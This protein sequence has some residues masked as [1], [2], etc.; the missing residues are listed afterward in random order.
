MTLKPIA[1]FSSAVHCQGYFLLCSSLPRIFL[2]SVIECILQ[3]C[4]Q[5]RGGGGGGGG[6]EEEGGSLMSF[7]SMSLLVLPLITFDLL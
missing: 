4:N 7:L 5:L 6:E 1:K 2:T 3:Y